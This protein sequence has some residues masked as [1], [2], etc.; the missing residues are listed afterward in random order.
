MPW[1]AHPLEIRLPGCGA[2]GRRPHRPLLLA[3]DVHATPALATCAP[4]DI[5]PEWDNV[6]KLLEYSTGLARFSGPGSWADMDM[7]F[8][9][10][11]ARGGCLLVWGDHG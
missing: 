5:R 8:G 3:P 7:L 9:A 1:K 2:L 4:Q 11:P 10:A 6:V